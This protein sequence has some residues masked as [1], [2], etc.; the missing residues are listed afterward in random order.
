ME[1]RHISAHIDR[2]A[3]DVYD[4][5]SDPTNLPHW[6]PGLGTS[7][8]KVNGEWVVESPMGRVIVAFAERNDLGVL[9]HNVTLPSGESIYNPMRV[10]AAGDGCEVVFALRRRPGVSDDDFD[11]D[12][13]AVLAD[14]TSLK[15]LMERR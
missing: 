10:T 2:P 11:G 6:A 1:T 14:L 7:V 4:F 12:A 15:E 3:Q 8:E 5:A 9:D 13:R